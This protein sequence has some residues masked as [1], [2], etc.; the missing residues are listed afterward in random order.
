MGGFVLH[1]FNAVVFT[2]FVVPEF[3]LLDF[4][5][6]LRGSLGQRESQQMS[7]LLLF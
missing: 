5:T 7:L 1:V 6:E 3:L 4:D 2:G